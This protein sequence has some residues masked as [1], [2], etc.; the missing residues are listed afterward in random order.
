[1]R[2][3]LVNRSLVATILVIVVLMA[4]LVLVCPDGI[5]V[6]MSGAMSSRCLVMTHSSVLGSAVGS[7]SSPLLASMTLAIAVGFAATLA[8]A[9]PTLL[10]DIGETPYGR[11]FDPLNGR[12]RI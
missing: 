2:L 7:D 10:A 4:A 1:M 9:R 11:S 12:L 5:H 6:P 3:A 8:L